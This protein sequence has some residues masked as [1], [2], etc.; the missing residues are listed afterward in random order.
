MGKLWWMLVINKGRFLGEKR[1]RDK[2]SIKFHVNKSKNTL[3]FGQKWK[4]LAL[5]LFFELNYSRD[6]SIS[7][8]KIANFSWSVSVNSF[9]LKH[10]SISEKHFCF[11]LLQTFRKKFF[12]EFHWLWKL[13]IRAFDFNSFPMK[14]SFW[15]EIG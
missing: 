3:A 14:S 12:T 7:T 11:P 5:S 1:L 4:A 9:P 8:T 15:K 10:E 6:I 2:C 13:P